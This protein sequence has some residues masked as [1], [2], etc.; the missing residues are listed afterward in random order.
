[1]NHELTETLLYSGGG[2]WARR[3]AS[4][5]LDLGGRDRACR[6]SPLAAAQRRRRASW[7][8]RP[9]PGAE[10]EGSRALPA[11]MR[12]HVHVSTSRDGAPGVV[13]LCAV[14]PDSCTQ[15]LCQP[16]LHASELVREAA[17]ITQWFEP[18]S[19]DEQR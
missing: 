10:E 15:G 18:A 14:F 11:E 12:G 19:W 2:A 9:R 5:P 7:D 1:M 13:P 4:V 3:P 8:R 17:R 16:S 6:A